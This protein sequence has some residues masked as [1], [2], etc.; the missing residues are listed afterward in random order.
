MLPQENDFD[1]EVSVSK[2]NKISVL[3]ITL[4]HKMLPFEIKF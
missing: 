3:W 4:K 1:S 2:W